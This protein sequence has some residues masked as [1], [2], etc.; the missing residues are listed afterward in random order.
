[1]FCRFSVA[2]LEFFNVF[3][4]PLVAHVSPS[5]RHLLKLMFLSPFVCH[6][7]PFTTVLPSVYRPCVALWT[8]PFPFTASSLH[9]RYFHRPLTS[10]CAKN[11][12]ILIEKQGAMY[13]SCL[14]CGF[15]SCLVIFREI[16]YFSPLNIVTLLRCYFQ[17]AEMAAGLYAL[18]GVE[19]AREWT[20][21]VTR[22]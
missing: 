18:H 11:N 8:S 14:P 13:Y 16:S 22:G 5:P 9:L 20:G 1:M 19:M 21:P 12:T 10:Q 17:C 15:E 2:L 7:S 6:L 3:L 4:S